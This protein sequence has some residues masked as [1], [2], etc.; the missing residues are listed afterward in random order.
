MHGIFT[1]EI[2]AL[3]GAGRTT[4]DFDDDQA[5][6]ALKLDMARQCWDESRHVEISVKLGDWMGT[7]IGEFTE[8][9]FLYEAACAD[10]PDPAALRREPRARRARDR[11]VQHDA[12]VRRHLRRPGARVLRR[13]DA[14]RR[15]DPREDGLG[16]AAPPHRG[17]PGAARACA[18]VPAHRRQALQPRW[19][20]RR[21]RREPDPARAQA[22]RWP[23]SPPTRSTR[24][25]RSRCRPRPRRR[26]WSAGLP[27][28]RESL[29]L[30]H[31]RSVHP[32][33]VRRR[34][35][36]LALAQDA[37]EIGVPR[38]RRRHDRSRRGAARTAHRVDVRGRRRREA[39]IWFSGGCFEDPQRQA[40]LEPE[41]TPGPSCGVRLLRGRT[42]STAGSR[43]RRPTG[44]SRTGSGR[45]GTP[46]P[47]VAWRSSEVPDRVPP[48]LHLPAVRRVQRRGRRRVR[49]ALV[50]RDAL[51]GRLSEMSDQL[52]AR[53]RP[54]PEGKEVAAAKRRSAP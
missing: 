40:G 22:A 52:A 38:R 37:A 48:A 1:G 23:A 43:T 31:S 39:K 20:P 33:Q 19:L 21:D 45:S 35:E 24:S 5:P 15:G 47:K 11:R 26:R 53:R 51:L 4:F 54:V 34:R 10:G 46:T 27:R 2:Q 49:S 28:P 30:G 9:T 16:L 13:L 3:E 29:D 44:R 41:I 18:R 50:R 17:R 8:A 36:L 14:R 32:G 25:R 6:F 7:E 42:G 12:R